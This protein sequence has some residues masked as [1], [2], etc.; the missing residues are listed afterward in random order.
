MEVSPQAAV[1]DWKIQSR[2]VHDVNI[3]EVGDMSTGQ[4]FRMQDGSAYEVS[5]AGALVRIDKDTR[6]KKE[7]NRERRRMRENISK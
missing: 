7:R 1:P 6:S 5:K 4:K 3:Y 2:K